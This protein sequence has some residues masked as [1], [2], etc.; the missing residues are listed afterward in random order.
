MVN[1]IWQHHFGEGLVRTPSNF[2]RMG[3]AATHP[4]LLDWL[5]CRFVES[6][7]SVKAMH[8][9]L[10]RS[11]AY[12]RSSAASPEALEKDPDN[13]LLARMNRCRLEAEAFR[14]AIL[15]VSGTLDRSRGGPP[16]RTSTAGGG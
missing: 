1:R 4:E 5:A 12:R 7:W 6:G 3:E 2:G 10:L 8:R 11:A 14:D 16:T 9:L 15:A 13:R